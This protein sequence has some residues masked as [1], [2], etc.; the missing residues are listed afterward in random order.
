M[1]HA[2]AADGAAGARDAHGRAH[3]LAVPDALEDGVGAE[4]AGQLAD[5]L[6]R[7]VAPL[8]DDIRRAELARQR[9]AVGVTAEH[10]DLLR[11]ETTG[12]DD[13]AET[14]RAITND[15]GNSCPVAHSPAAPRDGRCPSRRRASGATA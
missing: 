4:S 15:G 7:G 8:A 1:R 10:D 6:D 2:D 9:N 11:A 13:A 12:G 3:R 5:P 14:D